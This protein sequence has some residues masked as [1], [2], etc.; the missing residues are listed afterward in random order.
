MKRRSP[1]NGRRSRVQGSA[2]RVVIELN[3]TL[4][5]TTERIVITI[6]TAVKPGTPPDHGSEFGGAFVAGAKVG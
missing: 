1:L 6:E 4:A 3:C 2:V 5:P